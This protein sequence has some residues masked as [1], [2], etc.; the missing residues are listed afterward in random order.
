[1][2]P[3]QTIRV[4]RRAP[5]AAPALLPTPMPA[6]R[7]RGDN[8]SSNGNASVMPAARRKKRRF[9][10]WGEV[11]DM[12]VR[13]ARRLAR[14]NDFN[15]IEKSGHFEKAGRLSEAFGMSGARTEAHS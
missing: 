14:C 13:Q 4:G 8:D 15:F 10:T 5:I 1:M 11:E 12:G 2:L 7:T 9:T 6:P 3:T